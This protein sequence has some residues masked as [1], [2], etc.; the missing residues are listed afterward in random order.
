ML[1]SSLLPLALVACAPPT[2]DG[3]ATLFDLEAVPGF[4]L[5]DHVTG[6]TVSPA[7]AEGHAAAYYFGHAT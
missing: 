1:R 4:A 2:S 7:D 5:A 3:G 6:A